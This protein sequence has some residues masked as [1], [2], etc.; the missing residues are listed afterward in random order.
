M[1]LTSQRCH[2]AKKKKKNHKAIAQTPNW[3]CRVTP[4]QIRTNLFLWLVIQQGL[5]RKIA[6]HFFYG[7][8]WKESK[9]SKNNDFFENLI[10]VYYKNFKEETNQEM[11]SYTHKHTYI[12]IEFNHVN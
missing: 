11:N 9:F 7:Y 6:R 4:T 8:S 5:P 10:D 3:I 12:C 2:E 1:Y